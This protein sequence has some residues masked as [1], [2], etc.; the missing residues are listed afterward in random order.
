MS[1]RN[2]FMKRIGHDLRYAYV[3]LFSLK[4]LGSTL[5]GLAPFWTVA[6]VVST[7]LIA[8]FRPINCAIPE[9]VMGSTTHAG[10]SHGEAA[11]LP[12]FFDRATFAM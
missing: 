12:P 2:E 7:S 5:S 10:G 11:R 1:W 9:V 6:G 4:V 3:E 8:L